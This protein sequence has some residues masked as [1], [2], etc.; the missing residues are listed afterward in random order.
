MCICLNKNN[1][2]GSTFANYKESKV[3][4]LD[5]LFKKCAIMF[6]Y[7]N[8]SSFFTSSHD[9]RF[10][11]RE[12]RLYNVKVLAT[13]TSFVKNF[14]NYLSPVHFNS[15]P[16]H[17]KSYVNNKNNFKGCLSIVLFKELNLYT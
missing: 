5:L 7:S 9:K 2:V 11:T 12:N 16:N 4:S 14:I 13:N 10:P 15:L 1:R 6:V 8:S 3:L 17:I